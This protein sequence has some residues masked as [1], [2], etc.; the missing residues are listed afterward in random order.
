MARYFPFFAL[1][2]F[3]SVG[4]SSSARSEGGRMQKAAQGP[5]PSTQ[6]SGNIP[7][8][9]EN[10]AKKAEL[11]PDANKELTFDRSLL[12]S[13]GKAVDTGDKKL[14]AWYSKV[15]VGTQ[16][17]TGTPVFL[18]VGSEKGTT[19]SPETVNAI[20]KAAEAG[21]PEVQAC[22]GERRCVRLCEKNDKEAC[23]EWRC[24]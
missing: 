10:L 2:L 12:L 6:D 24:K 22:T 11:R 16:K 17:G 9:V 21:K 14:D 20:S 13:G 1:V 3:L 23:C 7:T 18:E 19:L 15:Q 4:V 8:T 5:G